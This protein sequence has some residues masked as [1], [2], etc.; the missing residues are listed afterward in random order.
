MRRWLTACGV[1]IALLLCVRAVALAH[2]MLLSSDPPQGGTVTASPARVRLVFSEPLEASVSGIAIV[3]VTGH[4]T[5]LE[6]SSDPRNVRALIAPLDSLPDGSYRVVWRTMSADGHSVEGSY[7]FQVR[8]RDAGGASPADT[9][10]ANVLPPDEPASQAMSWGPSIAG[11]PVVPSLLRAAA[12]GVLMAAAGLLAFL[13]WGADDHGGRGP[14]MRLV[15]ALANAATLLL[16]AHLVA[17]L[18]NGAPGHALDLEWSHR[19][20]G[21]ATGELEAWRIGLLVVALWALALARRPR[22]AAVFAFAS[23]A[24]SGAIGHPSA[25]VPL[26]SIPAKALHLMASALWLG[27][28]LWLATVPIGNHAIFRREAERVSSVAL[29]AVIVVAL[30][31]AVQSLLFLPSVGALFSTTYGRLVIAKM[32]GMAF[33]VAFGAHH[34]FRVMPRLHGVEVEPGGSSPEATVTCVM[35][36]RSVWREVAVMAA[37]IA[38]GGLLAYVSPNAPQAAIVAGVSTHP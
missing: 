34:R 3:D 9:T 23:L 6:V 10:H 31:G 30:S 13:A 21:S 36:R 12:V 20:L 1:A 22:I 29:A 7:V 16:V 8:S 11:A 33:L 17:W 19:A 27:G 15:G 32:L 24:V 35:L 37:V 5:K 26:A 25:I 18:I 4:S 2:A 28:L 14:A 38:L